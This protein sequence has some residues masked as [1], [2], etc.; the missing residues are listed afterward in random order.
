MNNLMAKFWSRLD[1]FFCVFFSA[2]IHRP[3]SYRSI[4][5]CKEESQF[6][7]I[8]EARAE[9]V[10]PFLS[11]RRSFSHEVEFHFIPTSSN[12]AISTSATKHLRETTRRA[13]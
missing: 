5:T 6:N 11:R 1:A 7:F 9:K 10:F 4:D 13:H 3:F 2:L 8:L 12:Y